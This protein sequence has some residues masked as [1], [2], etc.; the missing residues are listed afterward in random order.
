MDQFFNAALNQAKKSFKEGGIPV[1]SVLVYN[2]K[3]IGKGHNNRIQ[4]GSV[5]LHSELD[6]I[7]NAGRL[8]SSVYHN[9]VLYTTLIPCLMCT[10]A[11]LLYGI[12]KVIIG[13]NKSHMGSGNLLIENG[14]EVTILN[15]EDC[16]RLMNR[17]LD[18][19][20]KL[21]LENIGQP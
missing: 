5:I 16:I 1:G 6:A 7:E 10:G 15:N 4:K 21:W 19:N 9:S 12:P 13:E 17:F 20:Q 14:V 3:I 18:G 2:D 8:E 11:I